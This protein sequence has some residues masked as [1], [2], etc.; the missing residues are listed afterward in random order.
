MDYNV[1]DVIKGWYSDGY[2]V[3]RITEPSH[4]RSIKGE[5]LETNTCQ[6]VGQAWECY[7]FPWRH[8]FP[9]EILSRGTGKYHPPIKSEFLKGFQP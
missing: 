6:Q 5:I 2:L 4:E 7:G 1:G 8:K 3:L 9:T